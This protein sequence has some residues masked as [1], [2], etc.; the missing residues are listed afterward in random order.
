MG[1]PSTLFRLDG[2]T[3]LVTGAAG[4]IGRAISAGLAEA[5]ARVVMNDVNADALERARAQLAERGLAVSA[6]AFDIADGAA[7]TA[8]VD[9][10]VAEHGRL[11]I[12][13]NNAAIQNRRPVLDYTMDEWRRII[14]VNLS[15]VFAVAQAAGRVMARQAYGRIIN[16]GS[17]TAALGKPQLA[18]YSS[19]KA[20]ILGLTRVMAAELAGQGVTVNAIAPGY[21]ET[22]FNTALLADDEFV[23]WVERR[24]PAG[25]WGK[26]EDLVGAAVFLASDAAAYVN[27]ASLTIDGGLTASM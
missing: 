6:A 20:G 23:H 4:D 8:A 7:V 18:P 9:A 15:G 10:M 5:G 16:V 25:R 26:P 2:R 12:A 11:D 17:I 14:D 21:I 13:V 1:V 27:G 22:A 24:T 19:A 3:A